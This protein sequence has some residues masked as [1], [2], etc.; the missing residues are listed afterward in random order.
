MLEARPPT[1]KAGRRSQRRP[2]SAKGPSDLHPRALG[3]APV[4]VPARCQPS[5]RENRHRHRLRAVTERGLRAPGDHRDQPRRRPAATPHRS[6]SRSPRP[7]PPGCSLRRRSLRRRHHRR[8][9]HRR[10][11]Q[12]RAALRPRRSA[13]PSKSSLPSYEAIEVE[14]PVALKPARP[15][16]RA[17]SR[18]SGGG[19][20]ARRARPSRSASAPT[21]S[22]SASNASRSAP[23]KRAE[24]RRPRPAPTPSS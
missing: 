12:L 5:T 17:R 1:A 20:R 11:G 15:P 6:R 8:P 23:K 19:R 14:V 9:R 24:A 3:A 22:P 21:R 13:A 4:V 7:C 10:A 16:A 18:V 2:A